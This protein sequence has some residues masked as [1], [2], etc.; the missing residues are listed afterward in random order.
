MHDINP[1][2]TI[3]ACLECTPLYFTQDRTFLFTNEAQ[4]EFKYKKRMDCGGPHLLASKLHLD[5]G[6]HQVSALPDE[7]LLDVGHDVGVHLW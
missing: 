4:T 2:T 3:A 5:I 1:S 7:G 6:V